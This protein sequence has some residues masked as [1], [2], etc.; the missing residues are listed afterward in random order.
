MGDDPSGTLA[1]VRMVLLQLK[2]R[3]LTGSQMGTLAD[4][5]VC[6]SDAEDR[7]NDECCAAGPANV[8]EEDLKR[9]ARD[10]AARIA[11]QTQATVRWAR[12]QSS[13]SNVISVA[14]LQL[15]LRLGGTQP[16]LL[17]C[18]LACLCQHMRDRFTVA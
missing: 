4:G 15:C 10:A 5:D 16:A 6:I 3:V 18:T 2:R 12:N 11:A 1:W 7:K 8:T 13:Q 14:Q 17:A 9:K